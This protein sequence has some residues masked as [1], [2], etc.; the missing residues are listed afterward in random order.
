MKHHTKKVSYETAL[1]INKRV[2]LTALKVMCMGWYTFKTRIYNQKMI[3]KLRYAI[4][5]TENPK[6]LAILA[7]V[8]ELKEENQERVLNAIEGGLF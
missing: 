6:L 2:G 7:K 8:A 1:I 4:D 3:D 5:N